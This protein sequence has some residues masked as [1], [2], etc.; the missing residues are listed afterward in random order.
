MER[1]EQACQYFIECFKNSGIN[2]SINE[3]DILNGAN[4]DIQSYVRKIIE[5]LM[6]VPN[7]G[8]E[9]ISKA[10]NPLTGKDSLVLRKRI[11]EIETY[12]LKNLDKI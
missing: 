11:E 10:S 2:R 9:F 6:P 4:N 3:D 5:F 12:I 8:E 7:N 1:K